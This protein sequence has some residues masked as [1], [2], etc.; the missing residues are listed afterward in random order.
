[1]A[2][3]STLLHSFLNASKWIQSFFTTLLIGWSCRMFGMGRLSI[4]GQN[5][6]ADSIKS[7]PSVETKHPDHSGWIGLLAENSPGVSCLKL[8]WSKLPGNFRPENRCQDRL[9][10]LFP[11]QIEILGICLILCFFLLS[12]RFTSVGC[13]TMILISCRKVVNVMKY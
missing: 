1:M 13:E 4:L 12:Y 9:T 8:P 3:C 7:F 10:K 11:P 2:S 5:S 6:L